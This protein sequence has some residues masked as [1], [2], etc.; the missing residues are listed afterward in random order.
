MFRLPG[1]VVADGLVSQKSN[2]CSHAPSAGLSLHW[3]PAGTEPGVWKR[4]ALLRCGIALLDSALTPAC[5]DGL[6]YKHRL[7]RKEQAPQTGRTSSH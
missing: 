2:G 4:A 3:P 1:G 7:P 6:G 5:R